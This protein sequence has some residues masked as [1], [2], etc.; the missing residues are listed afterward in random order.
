MS[1]HF[2]I[3]D[4]KEAKEYLQSPVLGRRL[5][6]CANTVFSL[7]GKT[8]EQIFG[9]PDVLKLR[10]SMTLFEAASSSESV[11]SQVLKKYYRDERDEKTLTLLARN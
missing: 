3:Q 1:R 9:Y 11:F 2:E 4:I 8:A 6:E 10:S 7:S 5:V